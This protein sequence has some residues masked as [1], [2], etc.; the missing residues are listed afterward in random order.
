MWAF[1]RSE[2]TLKRRPL[3]ASLQAAFLAHL[4]ELEA[5]AA[6]QGQHEEELLEKWGEPVAG[7]ELLDDLVAFIRRYCVLPNCA[8]E[9][10]ALWALLTFAFRLFDVSPRVALTSPVKRCGKTTVLACL[11]ALVNEPLPGAC[12]TGPAVFH[13][14][15]AF[16]PTLLVDEFDLSGGSNRELR[17]VLNAGHRSNG[18]IPRVKRNYRCFA[19]VAFA[20]ILNPLRPTVPETLR[21]RSI[22]VRMHRKAENDKVEPFAASAVKEVAHPLRRKALR[23]AEDNALALIEASKSECRHPGLDDRANDNWRP[24][25]AVA[26]VVGERWAAL[27]DATARTLSGRRS[28]E[29]DSALILLS[30]I[31]S[32]FDSNEAARVPTRDLVS[33]LR[34]L[35]ESSWGRLNPQMLARHL[36]P[37]DVRPRTLR[38]GTVV[39]KGYERAD[40]E[41]AW[42]LYL[43]QGV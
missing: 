20:A 26:A 28:E 13:A 37:F 40:F 22:E 18:V 7:D 43:P 35:E 23:W 31:R 10:L 19:P 16:G 24:L 34:S 21:D 4:A 32:F 33:H 5:Q 25:F 29:E 38:I 15:E 14:V 3:Q 2:S 30:D 1:P 9:A 41:L 6:L 12:V 36:R 39:A 42:R 8:A 27:C 17:A 11:E